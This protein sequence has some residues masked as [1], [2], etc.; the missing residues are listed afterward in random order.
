MPVGRD[1]TRHSGRLQATESTRILDD[2]ARRRRL[3]KQLDAL[4]QDNFHEDPHAQLQWHKN[5]PRFDDEQVQGQGV[6]RKRVSTDSAEHSEGKKKKKFRAEHSKQ[7]FRKNF[8]ALVEEYS[9]S[10][11]MEGT[12]WDAYSAA[13]AP[14]SRYPP[15]RFCAVCGFFS[16]YTCIRCGARYCSVKCRDLHNDTSSN[17]RLER[18]ENNREAKQPAIAQLV[19]RRTVE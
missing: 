3:R 5:I 4:E 16:N 17:V 6:S 14:P 18:K 10:K 1:L 13:R 7:R 19:E 2:A 15:R 12:G 11:T 8:L 9:A